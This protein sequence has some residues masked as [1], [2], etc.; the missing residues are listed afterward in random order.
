MKSGGPWNDPGIGTR[1]IGVLGASDADTVNV[2]ASPAAE[3]NRASVLGSRTSGAG[4]M[5]RCATC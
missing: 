3:K 2:G 4:K 1:T 5:Q